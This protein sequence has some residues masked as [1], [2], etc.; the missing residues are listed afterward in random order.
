MKKFESKDLKKVFESIILL[1][2]LN[3]EPKS[4]SVVATN[5]PYA[6]SATSPTSAATGNDGSAANNAEPGKDGAPA[7]A[8][9]YTRTPPSI[10]KKEIKV[11]PA[12]G[13]ITIAELYGK[14]ENYSGKTIKI[15]GQVTKYTPMV[16]GK[17]WI[18]LQDGTDAVGKFDLTVTSAAELKVGDVVTLEGKV[19]L[20]KDLGYGYFFDVIVE[21]ATIIK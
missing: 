19:S 6:T 14:K 9:S 17:N 21:D 4:S 15:K 18:H 5:K 10:E 8:T 3:T 12:K 16:M 1:E 11:A 7:S 2:K 20:N 13:G